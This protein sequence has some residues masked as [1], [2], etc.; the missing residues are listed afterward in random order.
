MDVGCLM[1]LWGGGGRRS[2]GDGGEGS[3][4]VGV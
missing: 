1:G 4:V 3:R 2:R